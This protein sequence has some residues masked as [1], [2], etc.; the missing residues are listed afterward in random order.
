LPNINARLK[1]GGSQTISRL[2]LGC[3]GIQEKIL[4]KFAEFFL[5]GK[6]ELK[7]CS[8]TRGV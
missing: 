6:A 3:Q 8:N 2:P 1:R 4:K 7:A 5:S